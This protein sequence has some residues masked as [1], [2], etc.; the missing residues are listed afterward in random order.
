M[1]PEVQF[2]AFDLMEDIKCHREPQYV[3]NRL[4]WAVE[5]GDLLQQPGETQMMSDTLE[6]LV[7]FVIP[8]EPESKVIDELFR[9]LEYGCHYSTVDVNLDPLIDEVGYGS[10]D[11]A[12]LCRVLL[13][14]AKQGGD[15]HIDFVRAH[16]KSDHDVVRKNAEYAWDHRFAEREKRLRGE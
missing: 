4:Q 5:L 10:R 9:A 11:T 14:L 13:M 7:T 3:G 1:L 15:R 6:H 12:F 8:D 16:M 2:K